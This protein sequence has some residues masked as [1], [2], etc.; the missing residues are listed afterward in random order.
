M[1]S[2]QKCKAYIVTD[3][4]R[5]PVVNVTAVADRKKIGGMK[6]AVAIGRSLQMD[7]NCTF[8]F[9]AVLLGQVPATIS[10]TNTSAL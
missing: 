3:D 6:T 5:F 2:I 8:L 10:V 7:F 9:I 4:S 1:F